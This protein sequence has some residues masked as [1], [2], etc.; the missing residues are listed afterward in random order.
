MSCAIPE[1][2]FLREDLGSQN[3][4]RSGDLRPNN[5]SVG[6][7]QLVLQEEVVF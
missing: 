1:E 2:K 4:G 3:E 5:L 7:T 6:G